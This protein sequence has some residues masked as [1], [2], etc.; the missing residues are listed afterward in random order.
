[1]H[2]VSMRCGA[3]EPCND[4]RNE[5]LGESGDTVVGR[6]HTILRSEDHRASVPSPGERRAQCPRAAAIV[7]LHGAHPARPGADGDHS[8][9]DS[10]ELIEPP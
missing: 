9:A 3:K 4:A 6:A 2:N 5:S 7:Y 8:P 1:M 10:R